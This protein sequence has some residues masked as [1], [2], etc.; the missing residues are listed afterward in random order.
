MQYLITE[1]FKRRI[2]QHMKK[3]RSLLDDVLHSLET[4]SPNMHA[5]LGED[6]YKIRLR[7][8]AMPKGKNKSFRLVVLFMDNE[9]VIPLT[10]YYKGEQENILRKEIRYH[11]NMIQQE[12]QQG[13]V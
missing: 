12:I 6:T 10:L 4:F 9:C 1:Y 2:K 13:L 3:H 5:S 11:I 8:D 7:S